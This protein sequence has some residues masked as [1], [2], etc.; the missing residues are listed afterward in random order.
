MI[1]KASKPRSYRQTSELPTRKVLTGGLV[2]SVVLIAVWIINSF[3][4]L[5]GNKDIP[6]E[7][8]SALTILLTFI[9]SYL[10]PPSARDNI[11]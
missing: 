1:M 4:L 11:I 2:G 7:V 3:D 10:V 8:S 9:I 5:P 6:A